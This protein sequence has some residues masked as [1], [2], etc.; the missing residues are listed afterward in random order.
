MNLI[1]APSFT[2]VMPKIRRGVIREFYFRATIGA[3][4]SGLLIMA[5][6]YQ[7]EIVL[8]WI[9]KGRQIFE[10]PFFIWTTSVWM[11]R[12]IW[13]GVLVVGWVIGLWSGFKLGE[14]REFET[15]LENPQDATVL[16]EIIQTYKKETES[17]RYFDES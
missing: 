12:D 13:Y 1:N 10:F 2:V 3:I 11:A 4:F 5:S 16:K 7:L 6:L 17:R 9:Q 8:I 15:I 14:V